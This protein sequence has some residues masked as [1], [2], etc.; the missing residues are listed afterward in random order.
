MTKNP[1]L[2]RIWIALLISVALNSAVVILGAF[3]EHHSG[4]ALT[5]I[6]DLLS[7][8]GGALAELLIPAGHDAAQILGAIAVSL[9]SS[10]V[11]Y[12]ALVWIVLMAWAS[13]GTGGNDIKPPTM[14]PGNLS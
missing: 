6:L 12:G 1:Q 2:R 14:F 9:I 7:V 10:V 5:Q 8:P 4:S 3:T 13:R 11:F